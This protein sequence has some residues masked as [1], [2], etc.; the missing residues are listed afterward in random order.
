MV[1]LEDMMDR[2]VSAVMEEESAQRQLE[3][4]E[5]ERQARR[6]AGAALCRRD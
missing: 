6:P 1:S 5:Q 4:E 2:T 3:R